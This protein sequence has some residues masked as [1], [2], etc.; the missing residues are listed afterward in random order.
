[1]YWIYLAIFTVVIFVPTI[2]KN[3]LGNLSVVQTQEYAILFLGFIIFILFSVQ[4]KIY[5]RQKK[6][7]EEMLRKV[8]RMS[9][10]LTSSYSYIGEI[11]RKLDILEGITLEFPGSSR[12][13]A[14][15]Q[16]EL[17]ESIVSAIKLFG[18]GEDFV[19]R[20]IDHDNC[21]TLKEI[22]SHKD[23]LITLPQKSCGRDVR[24]LETE[25]YIVISTP[26]TVNN[27]TCSIIIKKKSQS[28]SIDD[29]EI[30]KTLAMQALSL[31]I[32]VNN[33]KNNEKTKA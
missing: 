29:L 28:H 9:K 17:Y 13:S 25:E 19:L 5:K 3:G 26:K 22:K 7:R 31:F 16:K 23:V 33:K 18:K 12:I 14:R 8:N 30:M 27:I 11:N 20:F 24:F 32:F 21:E 10:D 6:E 1:M 15:K 2:V 4:E